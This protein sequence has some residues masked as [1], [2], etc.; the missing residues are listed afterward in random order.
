MKHHII[1]LTGYAG[2]GKDTVADILATHCG[3]RKL[4]FA[5]P[6]RGEVAAAFDLPLVTFT[7]RATKEQATPWL[8]LERAPFEFRAALA[9]GAGTAEH[10]APIDDWLTAPRTPRQILQWWGTEY[11]RAQDPDYWVKATRQRLAHYINEQREQRFVVT[12]CRFPNEAQAIQAIGGQLWQVTRMGISA[13]T[14]TEGA[15]SSATSGAELEPHAIIQNHGT[16]H[17]LREQVLAQW[18]ALEA[19]LDSLAVRIGGAGPVASTQ[20]PDVNRLI[21]RLESVAECTEAG[22]SE[23]YDAEPIREAVRILRADVGTDETEL[24]DDA[25]SVLEVIV[26]DAPLD[27]FSDARRLIPRLRSRLGLPPVIGAT[28]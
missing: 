26:H 20:A 5:D 2:T 15:H 17:Q 21:G 25:R 23:K 7:C 1:A 18:W 28:A 12:D 27:T 14:T 11:R 9:F 24:L 3:F 19:G 10:F 6:L 13:A 16:I 22:V 8:R 4:A